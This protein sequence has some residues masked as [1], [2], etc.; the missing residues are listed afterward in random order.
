MALAFPTPGYEPFA[1]SSFWPALLLLLAV[2]AAVPALRPAGAFYAAACVAAYVVA[3]PLGGNVVRLGAL[4]AGPLAL[5]AIPRERR[6]VLV[7][8]VLPLAYWQLQAPIRDVVVAD[9]DLSTGAAYYAPL[10]RFLTA[11][12]PLGPRRIEVPFTRNHWEAALLAPSTALARG[13]ERQLDIAVN[14]L[15]YRPGLTAPAYR[16]WLEATGVAY[17]ALPD[18][19]LDASAAAEAALIR[20]GLP[21]LRRVAALPH[22][23]V[24]AVAGARPLASPP[25]TV[26]ALAADRFTLD[27]ARAGTSVVRLR[28]TRFWRAGGAC[29]E[30]APGGFTEVRVGRPGPVTVSARLDL[31]GLVGPGGGGC[32]GAG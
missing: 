29:V 2:A 24:F 8:L 9:G 7:L 15:F 27:F 14:G 5:V 32:R 4:F 30:R 1:A 26:L 16:A 18:T 23:Q 25:A 13:W 31:G 6:P 17:V 11:A 20:A 12:S 10:E 22:W 19:R 3:T 21:Y 28:F